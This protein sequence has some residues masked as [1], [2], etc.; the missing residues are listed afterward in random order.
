MLQLS[1][2]FLHFHLF[3][4]FFILS[5]DLNIILFYKSFNRFLI[6]SLDVLICRYSP[7]F[8]AFPALFISEE[9]HKSFYYPLCFRSQK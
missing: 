9:P 3:T 2:L 1:V 6:I 4:G 8:R 7:L 5:D